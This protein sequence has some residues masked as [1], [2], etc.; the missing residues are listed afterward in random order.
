MAMPDAEILVGILNAAREAGHGKKGEVYQQWADQLDC[1]VKT[2]HVWLNQI[3]DNRHSRKSRAD[4]GASALSREEALT[5]SSFTIESARKTG[6]RL[7]TVAQSVEILRA[8]GFIKA[9]FIDQ[10]S[11]EVKPLAASSIERALRTYGVH[12]EQ[13]RRPP[14]ARQLRSRHPNHVWQIDPSLCVLYYL[15]RDQGLSV[16][17]ADKYYKNKPDNIERIK[18]DRVWRYVI[19]DHTT[20]WI[21]VHYVLGAESGENISTAFIN[22]MQ[23]RG[24]NDPVHGVPKIVMLDAG[25]ANTG[26][27]FRNLCNALGVQL[28][29]TGVGNPRAKGQVE[30]ANNIVERQFEGGL[31]FQHTNSLDQLN[32]QAWQWMRNFNATKEHSRHG[33][34]R[35]AAWM[36]IKADQLIK[37][38]DVE[39]CKA[40][41]NE[42]PV[43]RVVDAFMQISWKGDKY[44]LEHIPMLSNKDKVLVARNPWK[45]D[46]LRVLREDAEGKTVFFEAEKIIENEWGF[47]QDAPVLGE[48][49]KAFAE[50]PNVKAQ[51][52]IEKIAMQANTEADAE[53]KRKA[54]ALPFGGKIDPYKPVKQGNADAPDWM[55]KRGTESELQPTRTVLKPY[56]IMQAAK[57]LR[58]QM[59]KDWQPAFTAT[60]KT[61]YPTGEVPQEDIETLRESL[62]RPAPALRVVGK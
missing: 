17:D 39:T 48:G 43:E 16:M 7:Y 6:K 2:L 22:A 38:P 42:K 40:L 55:E 52:A 18:N 51:K 41:T 57:A 20:G 60:L 34:T 30:G 24:S 56:N 59:G 36:M 46:V 14:P 37:A 12:P 3:S 58:G 11:G 62:L 35:F 1:S 47:N 15:P 25:S 23:W 45:P 27:I 44:D 13:M 4:K 9:E 28:E 8:N 33:M 31:K 21:Y 10:K 19:T 54:K 50:T 53:G 32:S 26:A 5:I 49:Y 61:K 29:V